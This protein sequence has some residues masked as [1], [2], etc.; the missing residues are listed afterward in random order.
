MERETERT[1]ALTTA[2]RIAIGELVA[3]FAHCS[4]YGDWDALAR[5]FTADVV[6]VIAGAPAYVGVAAQVEHARRSAEWTD[7]QNRHL[8]LNLCIEDDG[9]DR[10]RARYYLIN[11]VAGKA[12]FEPKIVL[13]ARM[14]D[15]VVRTAA[16]WRIARRE[17]DPDQPFAAPDAGAS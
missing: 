6:T 3:R 5:C 12:L 11:F 15:H 16:G 1:P 13:S 2:D 4:D 17:L 8:A 10:A 14:T 9:G 7:G